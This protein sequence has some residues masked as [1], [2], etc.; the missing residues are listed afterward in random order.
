MSRQG[1]GHRLVL[2]GALALAGLVWMPA[3]ASAGSLDNL[4]VKVAKNPDGPFKDNFQ[5]VSIPLGEKRTF[6]FEVRNKSDEKIMGYKF[7]D[8]WVEDFDDWSLRWTIGDTDITKLVALEAYAFNL[9]AHGTKLFKARVKHKAGT[10]T[11]VCLAGRSGPDSSTYANAYV[12]I[13]GFCV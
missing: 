13:N 9:R 2:I 11:N 3:G 5:D 1:T 7:F 10:D 8:Y 6:Y 4:N 12:G